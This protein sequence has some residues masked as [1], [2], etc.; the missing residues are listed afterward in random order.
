MSIPG[1]LGNTSAAFFRSCPK[2]FDLIVSAIGSVNP[3]VI[4]L[5]EVS[6]DQAARIARSL[7]MNYVY[8]W[9][10]SSGSYGVW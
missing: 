4:G 2:K 8:S 6:N 5:Q 1:L 10:N 7:Y 3:D 9:H